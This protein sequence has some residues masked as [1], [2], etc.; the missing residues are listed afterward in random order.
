[1][2][3]KLLRNINIFLLLVFLLL[4]ILL[5][6][7][8]NIKVASTPI[9]SWKEGVRSDCGV[10]LTGGPNRVREGLD[11]LAQ[12]SIQ[13][14]IISGVHPKSNLREIFPQLPFYGSID[15]K[16]IVLEKHSTTTYGNVQ[17]TLSLVE[18]LRCRDLVVITSRSHMYRS[19]RTF[20]AYFPKNFP[21]IPRAVHGGR[22]DEN[23]WDIWIETI[24]SLFYSTW[25]Y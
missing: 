5:A 11:L 20:K 1:M 23:E 4:L 8:E 3:K 6:Q 17:Q 12:G 18:A 2:N 10:V 21:L 22:A 14:L 15:E 13:R 16:N 19:M 24:K 9:H 7:R 25:A